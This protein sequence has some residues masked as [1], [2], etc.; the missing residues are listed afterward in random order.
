MIIDGRKITDQ[1]LFDCDVCIVGAGAAGIAIAVELV[2]QGVNVVLLESGGVQRAGRSARLYEGSTRDAGPHAP[3]HTGRTRRIGGTTSLWGGRCMPMDSIDFEVRDYL[4]LSGWPVSKEELDPYYRRAHDYCECGAY[5][6]CASSAFDSSSGQM[7][8]GFAEGDLTSRTLERWSPPTNFGIRYLSLLKQSDN[9]RAIVNATAVELVTDADGERLRC[10]LARTFRGNRIE[11]RPAWTILAGGGLE[12]T[13]LLLSSTSVHDQGIGNRSGWLGRC[14]MSHLHGVVSRI[15]LKRA[16]SVIFGYELDS[17]G[18]YCRRRLRPSFEAQRREGILNIYALLDRALIEDAGHGDAML[19][20]TFLAKTLLRKA[21]AGPTRGGKWNL[22]ISHFRNIL[23]GATGL[24][25]Q[26]PSFGRSRFLQS[27]RLP[28]VLVR[29]KSGAF[30]LYF[31]T[32]Q[33]PCRSNRVSLAD[34]RDELGMRRL[35]VEYAIRDA[36]V[37]SIY[38]AHMLIANELK[39]QDCGELTFVRP[40]PLE[41]IRESEAVLGHHLGTTRMSGSPTSGVVDRNCRVHDV[42]NLF[43]ASSSVFAT[44]GQAHPTLTV[45]ALAIRIADH[46]CTRIG[47]PVGS[48]VTRAPGNKPQR[49]KSPSR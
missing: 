43:V 24:A 36:D 25:T 11:I 18:I 49:A 6:Y 30:S 19:S 13:R 37:E 44:G 8:S 29:P 31:H 42:A 23:S 33:T 4:P 21:G 32:E 16:E 15:Q 22:Y 40:E 39:R 5:D 47:R 17:Q 45:V 7:I 27:R 14:Y 2:A 35:A 48:I 12:T 9:I 10:V 28:S 41:H 26:L 1:K 20:L 46:L 3:L 34:S 38:R